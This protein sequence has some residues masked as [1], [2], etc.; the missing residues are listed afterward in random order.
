MF[1]LS[2]WSRAAATTSLCRGIRAASPPILFHLASNLNISKAPLKR[3]NEQ[4][5]LLGKRKK[6]PAVHQALI[7]NFIRKHNRGTESF[8]CVPRLH[9]ARN[10]PAA[11]L[12]GHLCNITEVNNEVSSALFPMPLGRLSERK[13][14]ARQAG[15]RTPAAEVSPYMKDQRCRRRE[16]VLI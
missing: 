10:F 4:F 1:R 5:K 16:M 6:T 15:P 3:R 14:N 7:C 8:P 11:P 2:H 12:V 9:C 13:E